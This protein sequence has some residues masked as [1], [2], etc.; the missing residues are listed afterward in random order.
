MWVFSLFWSMIMY[1]VKYS[2]R[3]TGLFVC[4]QLGAEYR[5]ILA[6]YRSKRPVEFYKN[7]ILK[8]FRKR[9]QSFPSLKTDSET[10][11]FSW[12]FWGNLFEQLYYRAI[13]KGCFFRWNHASL[14][15]FR[16]KG[17]WQK[18]QICWTVFLIFSSK[19]TDFRNRTQKRN[20]NSREHLR[21]RVS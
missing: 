15:I 13:V 3:D 6:R 1:C 8:N 14:S 7:V 16:S 17:V 19:G 5:N 18:L 12:E 2:I 4:S 21:W 9:A 10:G 20:Q 11:I